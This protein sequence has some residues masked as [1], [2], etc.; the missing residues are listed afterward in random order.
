MG[1]DV[2]SAAQV[3]GAVAEMECVCFEC[4][5]GT[6]QPFPQY[7]GSEN[8]VFLKVCEYRCESAALAT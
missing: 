3:E 4:D 5:Q 2:R 8:L 1:R 6:W 7:L